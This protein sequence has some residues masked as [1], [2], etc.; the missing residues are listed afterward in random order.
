MC[1]LCVSYLS[2][3]VDSA[4]TL[5]KKGLN[6]AEKTQDNKHIANCLLILGNAYIQVGDYETA[7]K[8][9]EKCA[10]INEKINRPLE[11]ALAFNNIGNC[12]SDLGELL[13]ALQYHQKS[14]AIRE[15]HGDSKGLASSMLN[16][17]KVYLTQG[18]YAQAIKNAQKSYQI[19]T[20]YD[21]PRGMIIALS[22]IGNVHKLQ[23]NFPDALKYYQ[24][25]L[26][27]SEKYNHKVLSAT[28]LSNIGL[29]Y[30]AQ[31]DYKQAL[32]YM[33]KS[34]TIQEE[35]GN[36]RGLVLNNLGLV[37]REQGKY[38]QALFYFKESL[39]IIEKMGNAPGLAATTLNIGVIY[40]NYLKDH[41]T[42]LEYFLK[43]K[44]IFET[45]GDTARLSTTLQNVGTMYG[46]LGRFQE[47]ITSQEQAITYAKKVG[48]IEGLRDAYYSR[49]ELDSTM[50]NYALALQHY[51]LYVKYQDSLFNQD[52]TKE[53]GKL[54]AKYEIEKAQEAEKQR[55]EAEAKE[56]Q[57]QNNLQYQLI[58]V[59]VA[60]FF[61][62]LFF[63]GRLRLPML[64]SEGL[65]F[66]AFLM[67]F[68]YILII[69]E[70]IFDQYTDGIPIQKL[71]LNITLAAIFTPLH[72]FLERRLKKAVIKK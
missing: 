47:G 29:V 35:V 32:Q 3:S 63:V 2:I 20:Q 18:N 15:K 46:K 55:L 42:A 19:F 22:T 10:S 56:T 69:T 66:L 25:S 44:T 5:G 12:Y 7:I 6:L 14:K 64:I 38:E 39:A 57:R 11:T 1:E 26:Q 40:T 33:E 50:G 23:G 37:Y 8:N 24:K 49:S 21:E 27:L 54:E 48:F 71:G 68:E 28:A 45:I 16:M 61:L 67:L 36:L 51:K 43:A 34:K 30:W 62:G 17:G 59:G 60:V 9:F 58:F 65:I 41:K 70:P 72:R 13:L 31:K 53:I 4:L 52:K